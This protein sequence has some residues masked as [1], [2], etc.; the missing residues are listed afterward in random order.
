MDRAWR[1]EHSLSL[2]REMELLVF[3]HSGPPL[4]VFPTSGGRF[5][6]FE[7]HGLVESLAAPLES[8][9]LRLWCVDSIDQE[10]W[11]NAHA[12]PRERIRRHQQ[13]EHYIVRELAPV[14]CREC[15]T[16]FLGSMGCSF[17]GYHALNLA[18]R[19][20]EIFT[21]A[22]SLCGAFDLSGF[23]EG[24][25]DRE[26]YLHLPTHYLPRLED[27][28][29]LERLRRNTITLF[30]GL[31]DPCL[32]QNRRMHAILEEKGIPHGFTVWEKENSHDW[33]AWKQMLPVAIRAE[34][35]SH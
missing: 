22:V 7:D 32:E 33:P 14:I 17:G 20:P 29:F 26:A 5:F 28:W 30:T 13:Y 2:G 8:G 12:A 6:D 4:V 34:H 3:G 24:Y 31:D 25:C 9:E 27:P 21:S 15:R 16:E 18:L 11:Y 1:K 23:L 19:H 10:S 35:C